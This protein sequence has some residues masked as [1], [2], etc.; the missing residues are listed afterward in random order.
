MNSRLK[1]ALVTGAGTG[2][3]KHVTIALLREGYSVVLAGRRRY[4]LEATVHETKG[5]GSQTSVVPTDVR[6]PS[7]VRLLFLQARG[8]WPA[9]P[10]IQQRRDHRSFHSARR[11]HLRGMEVS[12]RHQPDRHVLLYTGSVQA[13]EE[14]G[15]SGRANYQQRIY[16]FAQPQAELCTIHGSEAWHH[17]PY[18]IYLSGRPEIQHRMW[19]DRHR[20]R[21]HGNGGKNAIWS[22]TS[23]R[24]SGG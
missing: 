15:A 17:R 21:C 3:G 6:D 13:H 7:S 10:L 22:S 20:Q 19:P 1:V 16:F 14:S 8:F 23:Q 11:P 4:P 12:R 2:I 18:Q 9:R 24:L 5:L